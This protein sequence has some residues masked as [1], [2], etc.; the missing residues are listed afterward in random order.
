MAII[1]PNLQPLS[2]LWSVYTAKQKA[3]VLTLED[4]GHLAFVVPPPFAPCRG[5]VPSANRIAWP[6]RV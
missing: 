3:L 2:R 4:E 5:L 6:L 1:S